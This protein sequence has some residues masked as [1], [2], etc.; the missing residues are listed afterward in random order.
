MSSS[1]PRRRSSTRSTRRP[2]KEVAALPDSFHREAI[3]TLLTEAKKEIPN[4]KIFCNARDLAALKAL[5]AGHAEFAKFTVGEPVD[6]D[7]GILSR[8]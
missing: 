5:I 3:K 4:G 2:D 1:T 8:R 6:I 7:G